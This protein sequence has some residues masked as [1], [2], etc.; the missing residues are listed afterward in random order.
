MN[1]T[2]D[3]IVREALMDCGYPI[4]YYLRFLNWALRGLR[5]FTFD[6]P[7]NIKEAKLNV[8]DYNAVIVPTGFVGACRVSIISGDL[9]LPIV[10]NTKLNGLYN[11]DSTGKKIKYSKPSEE[12]LLI[13]YYRLYAFEDNV[14]SNGEYLGRHF[15]YV[16][17]KVLSYKYIP[18]RGEIQFSADLAESQIHLTYITDGVSVTSANVIHPY[19]GELLNAWIMRKKAM[20]MKERG[21]VHPTFW[22]QNYKEQYTISK[23]RMSDITIDDIIE[24]GRRGHHADIKE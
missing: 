1:R 10:H 8:T 14:N 24:A 5:E 11:F 3:V 12:E 21:P 4:H 2:I 7:I 17:S 6:F 22:I 20:L 13:D 19:L 16:G 18:E 9:V 23:E 15:G